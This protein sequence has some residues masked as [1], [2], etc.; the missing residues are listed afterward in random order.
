MTGRS[1]NWSPV[2]G[3]GVLGLLATFPQDNPNNGNP[4][5]QENR[6][7]QHQQ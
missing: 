6:P 7:Q 1:P 3:R 4:G 5:Q 2:G